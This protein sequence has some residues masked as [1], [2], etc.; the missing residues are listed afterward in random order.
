MRIKRFKDHINEGLTDTPENYISSVLHKLQ[1][2][3]NSLFDNEDPAK[4]TELKDLNLNLESSEIS[5]YSKIQDCLK[6]KF[7]DEEALYDMTF[8]IDLEEAVPQNPDEEFSPDDITSCFVRFKK[9]ELDNFEMIGQITKNVEIDTIDADFLID[10]K[11][12]LDDSFGEP[13]EEFEIEF[14]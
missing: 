8:T 5:K 12:E 1:T 6:I 2:K 7:S 14:D 10:I 4:D 13:E 3:I 9:Y 11:I